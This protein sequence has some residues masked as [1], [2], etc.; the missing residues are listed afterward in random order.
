MIFT[1]F[2]YAAFLTVVVAVNWLLPTR[3]RVW[4][5]L[6]A[7]YAFYA[8]WSI[9][10]I[11]IL[12]LTTVV[13]WAAALAVP[14]LTGRARS[15]VTGAAVVVSGGS[16]LSFKVVEAFGFGDRGDATAAGGR[17]AP[18]ATRRRR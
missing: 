11:T 10:A 16:L 14:T 9:P 13:T 18:V 7:S 15:L 3:F 12:L 2:Q 1:S 6:E 17:A 8:T 5:L 4:W